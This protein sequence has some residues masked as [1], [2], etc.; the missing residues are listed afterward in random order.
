MKIMKILI[1]FTVIGRGKYKN[2]IFHVIFSNSDI[3]IPFLDIVLK[4]RMLVFH[5]HPEGRMSQILFYDSQTNILKISKKLG[6]ICPRRWHVPVGG[7]CP[8]RWHVPMGGI[9]PRRWDMSP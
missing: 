8:R 7:I 2:L 4:F 6:G 1:F 3:S 5:I 9:C